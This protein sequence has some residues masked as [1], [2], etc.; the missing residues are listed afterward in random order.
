M[1]QAT[2]NK[3]T[4]EMEIIEDDGTVKVIKYDPQ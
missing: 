2:L 1:T 4:L 3:D